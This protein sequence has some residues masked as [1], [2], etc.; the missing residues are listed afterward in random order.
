M[1][2]AIIT[3]EFAGFSHRQCESWWKNRGG[4]LSM[5]CRYTGLMPKLP[6]RC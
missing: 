1:S 3:T 5:V 2:L 4:V 6:G